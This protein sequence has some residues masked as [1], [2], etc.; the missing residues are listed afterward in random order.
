MEEKEKK[1]E[2]NVKNI[3][4]VFLHLGATPGVD[5]LIVKVERVC[6]SPTFFAAS[7]SAKVG[8][9][10]TATFDRAVSI[11]VAEQ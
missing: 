2:K 11:N 3:W 9:Q 7:C 10:R 5:F 8:R 1:H 6:R 4:K